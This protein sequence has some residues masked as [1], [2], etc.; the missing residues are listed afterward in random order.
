MS[1]MP[2]MH[3]M[4][5]D[6]A[7]WVAVLWSPSWGALFTS[8]IQKSV[9]QCKIL[10]PFFFF[11]LIS[12]SSFQ[13]IQ[14]CT[15]KTGTKDTKKKHAGTDSLLI[16]LCWRN[17]SR[18]KAQPHKQKKKK[19]E[20]ILVHARESAFVCMLLHVAW[21]TGR[22]SLGQEPTFWQETLVSLRALTSTSP[23]VETL[24]P[25]T[26]FVRPVLIT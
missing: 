21:L 3:S 13:M 23:F 26:F 12:T 18:T 25:E 9:F 22:S 2:Q 16:K 24:V 7:D 19:A 5:T 17:N 15:R 6:Y 8:P 20:A 11:I 4:R 1:G 14:N 10:S